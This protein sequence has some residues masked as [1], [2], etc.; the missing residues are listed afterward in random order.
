M[1]KPY[2]KLCST[3]NLPREEW[4]T[5]RQK[6]IGGSDA[7]AILEM[8][9]YGSPFSVYA[10]KL[11]FAP[12][13]EATEPMRFGTD[14]EPYVAE[15]F[16][17]QTGKKVRRV[18]AMLQSVAWPFMQANVDRWLVGEN[19]ILE[20]KT[21]TDRKEVGAIEPH[22]Y[23]QCMHYMAVTG[24]ERVYLAMYQRARF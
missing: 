6:G 14:M 1:T 18:N 9:K 24:A 11:G 10:E 16:V 19:A 5:L 20:C 22:Y 13:T 15:R 17:E 2:I 23:V 3:L 21:I 8:N 7:G 12:E 4:L